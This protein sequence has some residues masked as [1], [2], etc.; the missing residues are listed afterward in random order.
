MRGFGGLFGG[1]SLST[2]ILMGFVVRKDL[3]EAAI[4][5]HSIFY[6]FYSSQIK[7]LS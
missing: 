7:F 6:F 2:I 1:T 4:V 3:E 5:V